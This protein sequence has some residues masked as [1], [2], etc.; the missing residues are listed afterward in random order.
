MI[1]AI[2]LEGFRGVESHVRCF[3]HILNLA[4]KV[5]WLEIPC[6]ITMHYSHNMQAILSQFANQLGDDELTSNQAR[7]AAKPRRSMGSAATSTLIDS[8]SGDDET[9]SS[10]DDD[11]DD[12]DDGNE[13]NPD[14]EPSPLDVLDQDQDVIQAAEAAQEDD[15]DE[16][17]QSAEDCVTVLE[18]EQKLASTAVS[19][20]SVIFYIFTNHTL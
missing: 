2:D 9:H 8:N 6:A 15:L 3:P 14:T 16:A 11:D 13:Q 10:D 20:V 12:D 18:S 5:L 1:K 7:T 19:K 4:V 17:A